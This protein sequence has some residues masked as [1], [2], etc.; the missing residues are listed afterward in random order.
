[1]VITS[2]G[3]GVSGLN[4][5]S[6]SSCVASGKLYTY[7]VTLLPKRDDNPDLSVWQGLNVF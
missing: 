2:T 4:P 7:S 5:G 1:M 3:S 6:A